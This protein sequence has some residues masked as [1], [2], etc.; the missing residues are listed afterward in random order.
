MKGLG[1][2]AARKTTAAPGRTASAARQQSAVRNANQAVAGQKSAQRL[3]QNKTN[4]A[5]AS[6]RGSNNTG[7][8][9]GPAPASV[10]PRSTRPVIKG[11]ASQIKKGV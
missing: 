10:P 5:A 8:W 3:A 4:A 6:R 11:M 9:S 2:G 7:W 1:T